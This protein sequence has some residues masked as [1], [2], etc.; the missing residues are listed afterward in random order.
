MNICLAPESD[1]DWGAVQIASCVPPMRPLSPLRFYLALIM[2]LADLA[3]DETKLSV[4]LAVLHILV[5]R[6]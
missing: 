6:S 2:A 1:G 5:I 3:H 4:V